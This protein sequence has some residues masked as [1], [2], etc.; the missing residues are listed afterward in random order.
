MSPLPDG[1]PGRTPLPHRRQNMTLDIGFKAHRFSVCVGYDAAGAPREVFAD[2]E[3]GGGSDMHALLADACVI[4]SIALQHG[5]T[6]EQLAK[7]LGVVPAFHDG[8]EVEAHAS[9][10]GAIIAALT[11]RPELA[12]LA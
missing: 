2:M 9:P 11:Q 5:L 3:R 6:Q 4:I 1:N 8:L 10:I 12:R 7:S